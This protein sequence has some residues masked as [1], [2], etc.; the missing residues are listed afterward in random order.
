MIDFN[1]IAY[2]IDDLKD[3]QGE[4]PVVQAEWTC[5][6]LPEGLNISPSGKITG[7][8]TVVGDYTCNVQVSTNWGNT[9]KAINIK[10]E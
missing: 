9:T 2:Q 7:T 1:R 6:N 8:P 10:V 4:A 3:P 5:S